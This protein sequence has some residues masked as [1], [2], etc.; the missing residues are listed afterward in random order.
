[1]IQCVCFLYNYI[2]CIVRAVH[3]ERHEIVSHILLMHQ[4]N[5]YETI[6]NLLFNT[7]PN[8]LEGLQEAPIFTAAKIG[9][10]DLL[11]ALIARSG[12]PLNILLGQ[13]QKCVI[14]RPDGSNWERFDTPLSL[15][16]AM[17]ENY[18]VIETLADVNKSLYDGHPTSIDL[19]NTGI[20]SLPVEVFQLQNLCSVN[21]C[22]NLLTQLPFSKIP[23][24]FWPRLLQELNLS[25]NSLDYI[26]SQLFELACLKTLNISHNPIESLPEKWWTATSLVTLDVSFTDLKSLFIDAK[27]SD[28]LN[29]RAACASLPR[30]HSIVQGHFS[31]YGVD[32]IA[33]RVKSISDSLLQTLNAKNC[34]ITRFPHLLALVFPNLE[35]LN[36]SGNQLHSI[37]AINELPTSLAELDISKNNLKNSKHSRVFH[38]NSRSGALYS[39]MRHHDLDRLKTLKLG[40]N[41][42]LK[43]VFFSEEIIA[44]GYGNPRVFFSKLRRLNLAN[45]GLESAPNHLAELQYLTDLDFSNNPELIIPRGICNLEALV[46][47]I[48]DGVKDPIVNELNMFTLT[49]DKQIYLRQERYVILFVS[50]S[51]ILLFPQKLILVQDPR[52]LFLQMLYLKNFP[53]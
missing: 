30:S 45:C 13:R 9:N 43:N 23:S 18:P 42:E 1:M 16:L 37:C 22:N 3:S 17:P 33:C 24:K 6:T 19:S 41:V 7:D 28:N 8:S 26:P 14:P 53:Q 4:R 48:Y 27:E 49:R 40:N 38:R 29:R 44:P 20:N 35:I 12:I 46:N 36:L 39:C 34:K 5:K 51:W 11:R 50:Y 2:Y 25:H 52:N 10:P 47:F 32:D 15:L 31:L 21:V